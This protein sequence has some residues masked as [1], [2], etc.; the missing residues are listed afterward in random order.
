MP[1]PQTS[2]LTPERI[3]NAGNFLEELIVEYAINGSVDR[4]TLI[5]LREIRENFKKGRIPMGIFGLLR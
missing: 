3:S 5:R 1:L 4:S 2:E